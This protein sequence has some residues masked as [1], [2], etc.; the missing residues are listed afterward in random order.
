MKKVVRI[1]LRVFAILIALLLL[2]FTVA[3]FYIKQ[4]KQEFISFIESETGKSL[5]SGASLH[6]GEIGIGFK[7]TFPLVALTIDSVYLRDSLWN[8]HHHDLV[9]VNRIYATLDF[10]KLIKGRINILRLELDNPDIYLYTDSLGYSNTSIF[11]KSDKPVNGNTNRHEYPILE[12]SGGKVTLDESVKHK[13]FG[14]R[15]NQLDCNIQGK[16]MSPVMTADLNLDCVIDAMEFNRKNGSFL[17]NKS[18]RGDFRV[19]FNKDSR[20]LDFDDIHLS[21]DQQPFVFN[22]K[23]FFAKPGTPFMLDW[24]TKNFSFQKG[25]SFLSSN[26][27][28]TLEPYDISDV[29]ERLTGSLD[30]SEPSYPTPLIH[31]RVNV[32]D[33]NIKSPF[34]SINNA[35]FIATFTNEAIKFK[36]HED[37]NTVVRFSSFRGNY[38]GLDFH[39]DTIVLNNLKHPRIKV[40]VISDFDLSLANRF[41]D[42]NELAFTRGIGKINLSYSGSL[43]KPHDSSRLINGTITLMDAGIHY[44]SRKMSFTPVSGIIRFTG[45]DMIVENLKLHTGSSDLNMNGKVKSIFYL[46]NHMNDKL[47]LDWGIES[48]RLDFE[49]FTSFLIDKPKPAATE[50]NKSAP[51]KSVTAFTSKLTSADFRISLK[52]KKLIYKKLNVDSLHA[53]LVL[54]DH[55]VELKN[56]SMQHVAVPIDEGSTHKFYGFQIRGLDCNFQEKTGSPV[57]AM[58]LNLD[59][60][61]QAMTFKKANGPFLENKS[62]NGKF[63]IQFNKESKELDFAN[64]N[65]TVDQQPFV[66]T[67]KFFFAKAGTPFVLSWDTKNLSF[68]K[69]VSF[70]STNLKKTLEPY[71]ISDSI[72]HLVGSLDN[73]EPQYS[74]PLIHLWLNVEGSNIKSPFVAI[75]DASFTATFNN[76]SVKNKGHE[77]SNTVIHFSPFRGN[78]EK[79]NFHSDSIVLN[80]LIHPRVKLNVISDINLVNAN[81]FLSEN[82]LAFTQGSGKINLAYSGSLEKSHDS[83]RLLTGSITLNDA[84]IH[85][86]PRN[87]LFK[88]VNGI[89]RFTGKD[90][91]LENLKLYSG[92]SDLNMNG[93]IRNIFYLFNHLNDKLAIDWIIHSDRLDLDDFTTF[94]QQKTTP[95]IVEKEEQGPDKTVSEFTSKLTTS[96]FKI[97]LKAKKLSYRKFSVDSLRANLILD[98]NFVEFK[99]VSMQQ[100]GGT[101]NFQGI[102]RNE[103]VSNSFSLATQLKNVNISTLF[104]SFDNFGMESLTYKNIQ[105]FLSADIVMAGALTADAQLVPGKFTSTIHFNLQNG[106]LINFQPIAQIQEKILKKRNLSDIRFADLHDSLEARNG[107][108]IVHRMEIRSSVLSMFVNGIYNV[109]T[110]PDMSIQ[111]PLSNLKANKDSVLVDKG[112]NSHTGISARLRVRRGT[113]G[114]LDISW[115]PFNKATK[116]MDENEK[117]HL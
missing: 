43:E 33:R 48:N 10:W 92:S 45:R 64:I 2:A 30:N 77:D 79:M 73:S 24:D 71:D 94:L 58:D 83:S 115:D 52:A 85:Y 19:A 18:L 38:E 63:S 89:I 112:I 14:F 7:S 5:N 21:V 103:P 93:G 59:C 102:Y 11:K 53:T 57:V 95:A 114:K 91:I 51:D 106:E 110:G 46:F 65:L 90:M 37:T 69:G 47:S 35:S 68:R 22:G 8:R 15:I 44:V 40:N 17:E 99:D 111:V 107:E 113:D 36:G 72:E 25:V 62:L 60:I 82:E 13:F 20:E 29:M 61:I 84:G 32:A 6:I 116:E 4:H 108:I 42:E 56:V 49:D 97:S 75:D 74:T 41:L 66:F 86:K 67:G 31:L 55:S 26:L 104:Y 88:P 39:S 87:I 101:I 3:F 50:K 96:D 76:E 109:K 80:D 105:G 54:N 70:L 100:G 117:S 12:I 78:W 1:S 98:D 27:K 28:K 34:I 23:F 16:V 9:S 81:G